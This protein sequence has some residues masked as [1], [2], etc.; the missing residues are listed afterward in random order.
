MAAAI[1]HSHRNTDANAA[2]DLQKARLTAAEDVKILVPVEGSSAM[3]APPGV[4]VAP[5]RQGRSEA[6]LYAEMYV[7]DTLNLS[8]R[9]IWGRGGERRVR[10]SRRL[11]GDG[12]SGSFDESHLYMKLPGVCG[13]IGV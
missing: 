10:G 4:V 7:D 2:G 5:N 8:L 9:H 12:R 6:V 11:V 13:R 1:L 3:C